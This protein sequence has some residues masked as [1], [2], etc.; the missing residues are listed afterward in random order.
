MV[1]RFTE[2]CIAPV[3]LTLELFFETLLA[4]GVTL[5]QIVASYS[6]CLLTSV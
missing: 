5:S 2:V 1:P 6:T 4:L 3:G